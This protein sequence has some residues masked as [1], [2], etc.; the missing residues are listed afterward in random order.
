MRAN[1][2]ALVAYPQPDAAMQRIADRLRARGAVEENVGDPAIGDTEADA[3]A[4]LEPALVAECRHHGA[5]AGHGGDDAGMT[6]KRLH[7]AAIDVGLD[8]A[9]EQMR[10]LS[11][12][13]DHI[14]LIG[15]GGD[16]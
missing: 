7:E 16:R 5:V 6:G 10:P 12:D 11:A 15:T 14:G 1:V 8:A 4:I 13:L 3:G 9:A 2:R